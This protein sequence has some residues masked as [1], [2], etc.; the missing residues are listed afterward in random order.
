MVADEGRCQEMDRWKGWIEETSL[1]IQSMEGSDSTFWTVPPPPGFWG[2]KN[3]PTPL[4]LFFEIREAENVQKMYRRGAPV[5][6]FTM[7]ILL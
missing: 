2:G 5:D 4:R 1:G 7:S 3:A 6:F